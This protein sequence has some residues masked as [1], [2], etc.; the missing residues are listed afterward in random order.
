MMPDLSATRAALV[1]ALACALTLGGL[2]AW[3]AAGAAGSPAAP[4][5]TGARLLL[6]SNPD[7]TAAFF[8]IRNRGGADDEL[9]RVTSPAT[10]KA[11]LSRSVERD[12][13]GT[14]RM[15]RSMPLPAGR[16]VRMSLSGVDVMVNQPPSML[17]EGDVVPF[18]LHFR[19]SG[20][21]RV[22]AVVIRAGDL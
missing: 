2:W 15:V 19:D 22:D 10:G 7:V 1:P 8:D 11:M 17:R 14:M 16:T 12:G 4:Q 13:V 18:L 6:P 20:R 9:L 3:T 21:V 5:V